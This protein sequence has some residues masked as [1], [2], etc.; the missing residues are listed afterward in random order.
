M[1][2]RAHVF[3]Q[4]GV[5]CS[6]RQLWLLLLFRTRGTSFAYNLLLL[7]ASAA[8]ALDSWNA[9]A[10]TGA[11][12]AT[13]KKKSL[14]TSHNELDLLRG[15]ALNLLYNDF[16]DDPLVDRH[17]ADNLNIQKLAKTDRFFLFEKTLAKQNKRI[18]T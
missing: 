1:F 16:F 11:K 13:T 8:L 15:A 4:F 9:A 3:V 17:F 18:L 2:A 14:E 5:K 12:R 10:L 7:N 6:S